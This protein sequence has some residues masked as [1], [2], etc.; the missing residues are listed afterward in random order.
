MDIL[1]KYIS[2]DVSNI[3]IDYKYQIEHTNK[4]KSTLIKIQNLSRLKVPHRPS[5]YSLIHMYHRNTYY[6]NFKVCNKCGEITE[7]SR[8]YYMVF[9]CKCYC[10]KNIYKKIKY[11]TE[12]YVLY[13][14][15]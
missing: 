12:Q 14:L 8:I 15:F 13:E 2:K 11:N 9:R 10:R 5:D 1:S 7:V 3:I 4:F 6:I